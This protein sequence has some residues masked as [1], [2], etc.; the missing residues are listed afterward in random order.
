[1]SAKAEKT[2]KRLMRNCGFHQRQVKEERWEPGMLRFCPSIVKEVDEHSYN[3]NTVFQKVH[4]I[5]ND[6]RIEYNVGTPNVGTVSPFFCVERKGD[7]TLKEILQTRSNVSYI[8]LQ[9]S[10]TKKID[11]KKEEDIRLIVY[12]DVQPVFG[13]VIRAA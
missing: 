7:T 6:G 8:C 5:Y 4:I 10:Q 9:I 2:L 3:F 13:R 12:K 1:M 11:T